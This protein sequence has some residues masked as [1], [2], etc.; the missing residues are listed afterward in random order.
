MKKYVRNLKSQ[1]RIIFV[2]MIHIIT[3]V[4]NR[5]LHKFNLMD[6]MDMVLQKR[7]V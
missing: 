6:V 1:N 5:R 4:K 3:L 2:F 7:Y